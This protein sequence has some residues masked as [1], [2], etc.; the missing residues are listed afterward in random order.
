MPTAATP[1][2]SLSSN[3]EKQDVL[4]PAPAGGQVRGHR[5]I[6]STCWGSLSSRPGLRPFRL[7]GL[8]TGRPTSSPHCEQRV[9]SYTSVPPHCSATAATTLRRLL[10]LGTG[11]AGRPRIPSLRRTIAERLRNV[12]SMISR[13]YALGCAMEQLLR[14][15]C[16][17]TIARQWVST[18]GE[19][20]IS[21]R[22][23]G[24][25][26]G[27]HLARHCTRRRRPR[28]PYAEVEVSGVVHSSGPL[29]TRWHPYANLP[30]QSVA[31]LGSGPF[32]DPRWRSPVLVRFPVYGLAEVLSRALHASLP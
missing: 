7:R 26:A 21:V 29:S 12:A 20:E 9:W 15:R 5:T 4:R 32:R 27:V 22:P 17:L 1:A 11:R 18:D 16:A 28:I 13:L 6:C 19:N 14:S 3:G 8:A 30:F 31:V 2:G 10:R 25:P 24:P 23:E